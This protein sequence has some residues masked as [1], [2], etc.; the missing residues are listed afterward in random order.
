MPFNPLRILAGVVALFFLWGGT[1][2]LRAGEARVRSG[3]STTRIKRSESPQIFWGY[4]A[5]AFG[6]PF[7]YLMWFAIFGE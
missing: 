6:G 5:L 7:L 1:S 3:R 4:V 2:T